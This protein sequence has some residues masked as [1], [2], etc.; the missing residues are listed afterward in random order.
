MLN[1]ISLSP[2]C[3]HCSSKE[4]WEP[5]IYRF[6]ECHCENC[7]GK[8]YYSLEYRFFIHCFFWSVLLFWGLGRLLLTKETEQ[9]V[10][11]VGLVSMIILPFTYGLIVHFYKRTIVISSEAIQAQKRIY[12]G[13]TLITGVIAVV[14]MVTIGA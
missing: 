13:V 5:D 4:V 14:I 3:P 7:D 6:E 10:V 9:W 12:W 11:E 2:K 1:K 8:Y